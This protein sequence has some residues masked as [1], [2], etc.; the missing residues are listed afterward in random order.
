MLIS[1]TAFLRY[2]A[3]EVKYGHLFKHFT[4]KCDSNL[5]LRS[6]FFKA[7]M[8][9][10]KLNQDRASGKMDYSRIILHIIY[11]IVYYIIFNHTPT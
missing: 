2:F 7:P 8:I 10:F 6:N 3:K 5:R 1:F 11:Y 4:A 9:V